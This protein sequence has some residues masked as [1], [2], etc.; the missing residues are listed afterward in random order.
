[1]YVPWRRVASWHCS[2]CGICCMKFKPKLTFYEYLKFREMGFSSFVEEKAG[3]YYIR[4]INGKCP[5][6]VGRLCSLQGEKKPLSCKVF[7]FLVSR[8]KSG[9]AGREDEALIEVGGE[10][11]FVYVSTDCPNT[12]LGKA[13]REMEMLATQAVMLVTCGARLKDWSITCRKPES[14]NPEKTSRNDADSSGFS[15]IAWSKAQQTY[16]L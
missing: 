16:R 3:R 9:R 15:R 11:F 5:F 4:K 7:P 8:R 14:L 1:M 10:E 12:V 6:Q 13:G 2:A